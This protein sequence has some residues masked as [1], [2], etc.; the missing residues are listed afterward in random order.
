M[1]RLGRENN[2]WIFYVSQG[3]AHRPFRPLE[4]GPHFQTG[5]F[6]EVT[7]TEFGLRSA[8]EG[9]MAGIED[10]QPDLAASE[11]KPLG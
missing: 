6:T 11:G 3:K 10:H 8:I 4:A 5:V 9:L 7:Q 2:I 1:L